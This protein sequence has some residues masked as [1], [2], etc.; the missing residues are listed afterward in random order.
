MEAE[1]AIWDKLSEEKIKTM[2][3]AVRAKVRAAVNAVEK[4]L[5][6]KLRVVEGMRSFQRSTDLFNQPFDKKDNDGDGLV[7]EADEKVSNAKAGESLHNYGLAWDAVPIVNGK[8]AY[9]TAPWDKIAAVIKRYGWAWG[10]DFKGFK[11]KPHFEMRFGKT[12]KN[13]QHLY[14][15]KNVDGAGY[16]NIA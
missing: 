3:P 8:A 15:T 4:E 11:D 9:K 10:G 5:G 2:H 7:D 6:I 1:E 14:A 13:L 12:L 16:V